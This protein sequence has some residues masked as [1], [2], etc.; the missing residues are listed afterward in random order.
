MRGPAQREV[1]AR[2]SHGSKG[3][4]RAAGFP[5]AHLGTLDF[6][7]ARENVLLLGPPDTGKTYPATGLAIRA[8]P[9]RHRVLFATA[10][11]WVTG[12]RGPSRGRLQD[13][14]R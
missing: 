11:E 6:L 5:P 7:T 12:R 3:R 10:T 4:I 2:E 13:E 8:C 9:A 1:A 14:L